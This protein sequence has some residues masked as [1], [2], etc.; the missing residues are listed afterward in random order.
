LAATHQV[1]ALKQTVAKLIENHGSG[2]AA[3]GT[4]DHITM[5]LAKYPDAMQTVDLPR[6]LAPLVR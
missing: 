2:I 4:R 3:V 1:G 6:D 5:L